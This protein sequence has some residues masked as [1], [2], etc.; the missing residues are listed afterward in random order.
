MSTA[1]GDFRR[2][3]ASL[4]QRSVAS[5]GGGELRPSMHGSHSP[6]RHLLRS[7]LVMPLILLSACGGR[8]AERVGPGGG[9]RG[10]AASLSS[11]DAA[12]DRGFSR[13]LAPRTFVFPADHGPHPDFRTEWWYVTGHLKSREGRSFGFQW[14]LFRR[15][16]APVAAERA[17]RWGARDVYLGHFAVSDLAPGGSGFRSFERFRRAALGLAGA[18]ATPFRVWLDDWSLESAAPA[19]PGDP[20]GPVWPAHLRARAGRGADTRRLDLVLDEGVPPVLQGDR[21]LSKKGPAPGEASYYYSLPR[22]PAR[23][24]VQIGATSFEVTGI[25][26]LDR[27]WSTGGLPAGLAGWDWFALRLADGR[28]VMLYR[29]RQEDGTAAPESLG[30]VIGV[31]GSA[32]TVEWGKLELGETATWTSRRSGSRYPAGW[33]IRIPGESLDLEL[34]P[35]LADQELAGPFTYWEGAVAVSGTSGGRPIAGDGYVELT[36]YADRSGHERP[37]GG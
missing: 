37:P 23:G 31:D 6:K 36:G 32:R 9:A 19:K 17:S 22:M 29:L 3:G 20:S 33:R 7:L 4:R 16:L 12:E 11:R 28:E 2:G 27:E 5:A 8:P 14:T 34:R 21:G 15:A 10:V 1:L 18:T 13:A 26:W 25:A 30:T 24:T 35:K